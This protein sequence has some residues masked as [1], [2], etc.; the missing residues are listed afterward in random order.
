[1]LIINSNAITVQLYIITYNCNNNQTLI[2]P[3]RQVKVDF[4][5]QTTTNDDDDGEMKLKLN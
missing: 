2:D 4:G 5:I 3:Y 1:M